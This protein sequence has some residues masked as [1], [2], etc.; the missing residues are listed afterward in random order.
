MKIAERTETRVKWVDG[1]GNWLAEAE[2]AKK[3]EPW[4]IRY[5]DGEERFAGAQE[6]MIRHAQKHLSDT[7]AP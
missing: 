1:V 5:E 4:T 2:R 3:R 7:G 6:A